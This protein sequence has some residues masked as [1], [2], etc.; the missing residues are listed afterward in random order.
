M[1]WLPSAYL[2]CLL[3]VSAYINR[4][5]DEN[6]N[7]LGTIPPEWSAWF[8]LSELCVLLPAYKNPSN[9]D[10]VDFPNSTLHHIAGLSIMS[11][12]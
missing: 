3:R 4:F 10:F 6:T 8:K 9:A 7:L 2:N 11:Y 1:I 5:L 12:G